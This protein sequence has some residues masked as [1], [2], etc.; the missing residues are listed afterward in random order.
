MIE[1][2]LY[3]WTGIFKVL[4][5]LVVGLILGLFATKYQKRKEVELK[6]KG[7]LLLKRLEALEKINK[8]NCELYNILAPAPEE[9][10]LIYK[11]IE[12]SKFSEMD[13]E[14]PIFMWSQDN[15]DDYYKRLTQLAMHERIY[16]DYDIEEKISEYSN[17]LTKIKLI[18]DAY[19]DTE[20]GDLIKIDFAFSLL[21]VALQQDFKRF[22]GTID[23]S[24]AKQMRNISLSYKDLYFKNSFRKAHYKLIKRLEKYLEYSGFKGKISRK[25]YYGY[26]YRNYGNSTLINLNSEILNLLMYIHYSDTYSIEEFDNLPDDEIKQLLRDFH[27][28]FISNYHVQ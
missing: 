17:Y 12:G 28:Q 9:Q 2:S 6:V 23:Q 8:I 24:I 14:Y 19:W 26:V 7:N 21:G 4:E 15:F 16:F 11:Y 20:K 5:V 25:I 3:I 27:N 18:M 1:F 13:I 10:I 22:H